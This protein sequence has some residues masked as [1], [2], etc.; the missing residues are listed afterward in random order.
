MYNKVTKIYDDMKKFILLFAMAIISLTAV[1]AQRI[2]KIYG[3]NNMPAFPNWVNFETDTL[4]YNPTGNPPRLNVSVFFAIVYENGS[5]PLEKDDVIVLDLQLSTTSIFDD[6]GDTLFHVLDA[7]LAANDTLWIDLNNIPVSM[8]MYPNVF[9]EIGNLDK[10]SITAVLY[11]T[12]QFAV[13][14]GNR[15]K[16][17]TAHFLRTTG[18]SSL[19]EKVIQNV[20]LFPNPV[21]SNLNITNLSNTKVE[22]FNVVGQRISAYEN[23]N[24]NLNVDMTAYPNG[25]YFVKMQNGK[26]VRTEKIKLVK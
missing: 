1:E 10:G 4:K 18:S 24:G 20:Q 11:R 13:S 7:P 6:I 3:K 14:S 25:I 8:N 9:T 12:S 22:I 26:S 21:N 17:V 2:T 16:Q 5:T 23:A 15:T 19:T